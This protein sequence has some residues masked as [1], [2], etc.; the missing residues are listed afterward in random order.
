LV[1]ERSDVYCHHA[2]DIHVHFGERLNEC[3][4]NGDDRLYADSN[5]CRRLRHLLANHYG[6]RGK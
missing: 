1:N 2:R 5:R 3:K 6:K 4:S